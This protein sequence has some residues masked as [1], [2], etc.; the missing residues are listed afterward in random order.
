MIKLYNKLEATTYVRIGYN[1]NI[2][3]PLIY[4]LVYFFKSGIYNSNAVFKKKTLQI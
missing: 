2:R 1:N 3:M 4:N